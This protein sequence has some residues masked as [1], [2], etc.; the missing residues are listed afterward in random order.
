MPEDDPRESIQTAFSGS[1]FAGDFL[2]DGIT[3]E[4]EWEEFDDSELDALESTLREIFDNFPIGGSPNESQTEEDLIWRVLS[5]F[6]WESNLRQQNLSPHGRREVPDGLLFENEAEKAK[7]NRV[8]E[9]PGRYEFG[10]AIVE[11]KRWE[12]PLDRRSGSD[13]DPQ[14]PLGFSQA[15]P[16]TPR[17]PVMETAPSTQMLRYLRRV[18]DLTGGKLRWGILTNG[19]RWRLYFQ[20]ARSVSEQFFEVDLARILNLPGYSDDLFAFPG[21]ARRHCLKVFAL[22]FRREAFLPHS[23]ES[24]TFH[25]LAMDQ[26]RRYE[27][28]V[29]NSLYEQIFQDRQNRDKQEENPIFPEL[30][31]AIAAAAPDAPLPEVREAA[32]VILYRLLFILYAEDRNL[33]PVRDSRYDDYGL[34]KVRD[35]IERRKNLR[36]TF[37]TSATPYWSAFDD[38]CR[39]IDAGDASIGLPPYNGGLFDSERTPLLEQVRLHDQ[40]MANVIDVLS[41]EIIGG[42]RRYINYRDLGVQQLGSIYERLL[43]QEVVRVGNDLEVRLSPF[44]R[45]GSGSYYTPDDL[46]GLIIEEAVGPLIQ[47]RMDAFNAQVPDSAEDQ[48]P[49]T[50][51]MEELKRLDPA[52]RIL[53]LKIC[54]P[55]MGSGHF[56][57]NLVDYLADRVI[58]AMAEAEAA[59]KSYVSPLTERVEEIRETIKRNA[60]RGGWRGDE[61]QLD[62][63]HV[64]RRMVLKRCVHGVDKNP[65]AVELA[66]VALWLHTFTVG[67]P[68]G[69]LDHHLCCGDSLFGS[70][71]KTGI[72]RAGNPLF[73][74]EPIERATEAAA[75]MQEVEK[76]TDAE[77]A[78]AHE[79]AERFTEVEKGTKPLAAFLSLFHA[80]DWLNPSDKE[81]KAALRDFLNGQF[82][83]PV[84]IALGEAPKKRRGVRRLAALLERAR[85]LIG[86]ERFLHWQVAFPGV[87]SEWEN[88]EREGGFDAVI[89]N[90]PWDRVKLQQVEWFAARRPE[91]ARAT[92]AADRK[93]MIA[94]LEKAE[95]PLA[96]EFAEASERAK[97]AA[98]V[99]R[100]C[101]DYPL[102]SGGDVN[103]YSLF[104]ER[105]MALVKPEGMVG[106]LTPSGIASDKTAARFFKGVST[107]GR[108]KA[109]YDFENKKIFFPDVHASFKFC[110]FV[111]SPSKIEESAKCA[112]YLN[113]VAEIKATDSKRRFSLSADDFASVNPNT[114]TAP[115]FR[116]E[117][118]AK[119]TTTIY[120]RLPVLVDRSSGEEE[121][122]WPVKY[123]TMFHMTNDS[124]LFRTREELEENEGAWSI[125]GN[126]YRNKAGD[127]LPLYEG[128]MV[129]AFD[130]RAASVVVN[131]QNQHRPAQP[132]P[133]T[134]VQHRDPNWLPTPQYWILES[135]TSLSATPYLLTFKDVT[136]PTNIRS[137]IAML[138]PNSGVGNTLPIVSIDEGNVTEAAILLA[139]LNA[140]PFDY[141]AR[142]KIQGQHLNW[143]IVEQLP[144]VLPEAFDTTSFGH[145]TAGEIVR[146]AVLE[147]TYT[148]H[149][150]APF[151]RDMGYVDEKGEVL[152][153]FAWDE[154]RR[155]RLRA[156]LDAVFFHLYGVTDRDDVR[157][158]YST[159]PIVQREDT[160]TYGD[161]RSRDLC[162][163]Y[164]NALAAGAPDAEINL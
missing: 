161:Y 99:A 156:K 40:I 157:Y 149:D 147:L 125:G 127:W 62:D 142:Q 69:F 100:N 98:H 3:D 6:G 95:D 53:E 145:K 148:A 122:A 111:A 91:I 29:A 144:V 23:A 92:R 25:Q 56:L 66:K 58:A 150:M 34:R 59:V 7:A 155:L 109:L 46:V 115:I 140:I 14:L 51:K 113:G 87:W 123:S 117:Q 48:P 11:S 76:L 130:H 79:S 16:G 97:T 78:E 164:M 102:L 9:G 72:D 129:Q 85:N 55:A 67:A 1:M 107:E 20:G 47:S 110:V 71:V 162:L 18:D 37:S 101:G 17:R 104:V 106:L 114:G 163:G 139:N 151:A 24:R 70:W 83:D 126:R 84:E 8:P 138:I 26:G 28:R 159:F 10:L 119:L 35:N 41:F 80:F 82:G 93:R 2:C 121:K 65:M 38:L 88:A 73:L 134:L 103:L 33:L 75:P 64:V 39:A 120:N 15:S 27:K 68:L 131:P 128:K 158:I 43:E 143:F 132:Q 57:V 31:A 44:A 116:T 52:E 133:A 13:L 152:Q 42:V 4:D 124:G 81:D 36:D 50:E 96:H 54:D 22:M 45:K 108:L 49:E 63:R 153:P 105:A 135:E 77:I 90:P 21:D 32:L 146:K 30:V 89:G 12:R 19:A 61:A 86:E 141:I 137:M 94:D 118:D 136:A 154:T 5:C 60:Q 74:R 112:F 160:N